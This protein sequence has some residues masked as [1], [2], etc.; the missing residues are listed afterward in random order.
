MTPACLAYQSFPSGRHACRRVRGAQ[1]LRHK[2]D[3]LAATFPA[4]PLSHVWQLWRGCRTMRRI[5]RISTTSRCELLVE[6]GHLPSASPFGPDATL[7]S[8]GISLHCL[9][10]LPTAIG[11]VARDSQLRARQSPGCAN[12]QPQFFGLLSFQEGPARRA[13]ARDASADG[14]LATVYRSEAFYMH[15]F[16]ILPCSKVT[17]RRPLR[18]PACG[19]RGSTKMML[20]AVRRAGRSCGAAAPRPCAIGAAGTWFEPHG[21]TRRALPAAVTG[22]LLQPH[23]CLTWLLRVPAALRTRLDELPVCPPI[24]EGAPPQSA[25]IQLRL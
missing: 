13:M 2:L 20:P 1:Q 3:Q 16:K 9:A 10:G 19:L 14:D 21:G 4:G 7:G 11:L 22:L 24:R 8:Q 5:A 18:R 12:R 15:C 23:M 25:R 6:A 17:S